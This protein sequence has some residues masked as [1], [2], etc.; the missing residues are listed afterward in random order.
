MKW[1]EYVDFIKVSK[2]L[3]CILQE[4]S[5]SNKCKLEWLW[6]LKHNCLDFI[7]HSVDLTGWEVTRTI[8]ELDD[9]SH[10]VF[11][12]VSLCSHYWEPHWVLHW[13]SRCRWHLI[14]RSLSDLML[15]YHNVGTHLH[16]LPQME[17][18]I[19]IFAS[20]PDV[21]KVRSM[22]FTIQLWF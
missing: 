6:W 3:R 12:R 14:F 1:L 19:G 2:A 5:D 17:K 22:R 13:R 7:V 4:S 20:P 8:L 21:I 9:H 16:Q 10:W 18:E 15:L 11:W